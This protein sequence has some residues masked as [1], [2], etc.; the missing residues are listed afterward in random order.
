MAPTGNTTRIEGALL[1]KLRTLVL[2]PARPVAWP[3]TTYTPVV[4]TIYLAPGFLW[5][6]T[7]RGETGS[8]SARRHVGIF[9]VN[10]RGPAIGNPE[11]D[12]EIADRIIE[13]FDRQVIP[14]NSVI[15]RIGSF[16]G[17]RAVPWRGGALTED[18]WR[19]IA[20]SI[21]FW[22]DVFPT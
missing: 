7:E 5:N 3:G 4:G 19:L 22:C 20:V 11:T 1:D 18:G 12:A 13:H 6:S 8:Q 14:H 17:G 15:V 9:Q 21:P 2:N 16:N 10:V